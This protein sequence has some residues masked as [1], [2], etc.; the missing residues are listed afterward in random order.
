MYDDP[1]GDTL[2]GH[3]PASSRAAVTFGTVGLWATSAFMLLRSHARRM[4][5]NE[6]HRAIRSRV[7]R[8][9]WLFLAIYA[10]SI[11]LAFVEP[12]LSW[13]CF[14]SVAAML[15]VPV[16]GAQRA[17]ESATGDNHNLERSCP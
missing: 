16:I 4:S 15:F 8:R 1:A 6:L 10:A 9:T 2:L 3:F 13:L 5:H 17:R 7:L 14:A 11:P 12:W